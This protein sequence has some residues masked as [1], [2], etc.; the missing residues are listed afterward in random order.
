MLNIVNSFSE[1]TE[2]ELGVYFPTFFLNISNL[3]RFA[4]LPEVPVISGHFSLQITLGGTCHSKAICRREEHYNR[5]TSSTVP[6]PVRLSFGVPKFTSKGHVSLYFVCD[7]GGWWKI[8]AHQPFVLS[9]VGRTGT[10]SARNNSRPSA[11]V[12]LPKTCLHF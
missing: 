10:A 3:Y 6:S 4:I 8:P 9:L 12:Q 2:Y 5:T 11:F 1:I 7:W